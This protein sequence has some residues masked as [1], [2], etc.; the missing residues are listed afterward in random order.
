MVEV[1]DVSLF[2]VSEGYPEGSSPAIEVRKLH[3]WEMA[4]MGLMVGGI[5]STSSTGVQCGW[6]VSIRWKNEKVACTEASF[7]RRLDAM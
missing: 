4:S 7:D 2:S 3:V 1:A 5:M 6:N